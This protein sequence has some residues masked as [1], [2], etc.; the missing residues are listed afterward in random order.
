MIEY[1]SYTEYCDGKYTTTTK[2]FNWDKVDASWSGCHWDNPAI[3]KAEVVD[4]QTWSDE[5]SDFIREVGATEI[6]S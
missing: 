5:M 6:V 3:I 2:V 4:G 1:E